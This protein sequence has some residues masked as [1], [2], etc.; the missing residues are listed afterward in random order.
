MEK[1]NTIYDLKLHEILVISS[2]VNS[3]SKTTVLRVPGGWIYTI[4]NS[5]DWP[6]D[7]K[8]KRETSV[9]IPFHTEFK[10]EQEFNVM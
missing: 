3:S 6:Q 4:L 2:T 5:S 9:F 10:P 1:E 8:Q 7:G